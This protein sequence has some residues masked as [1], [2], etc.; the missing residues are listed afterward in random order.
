MHQIKTLGF[1]GVGIMGEPI[2]RHLAQKSKM[3]I[4]AADKQFAALERLSKFGVL[5]STIT[6]IA[7]ESDIIFMSL[8]S[9]EIVEDVVFGETGLLNTMRSD[10]IVVDLSTSRAQTAKK[11]GAALMTR[12]IYFADAPVMRTRAAA[13]S[14]TLGIPVGC[15]IDVFNRI[16]KFLKMFGSD[17]MHCGEIGSGQIA[18]I[19]NN[20][21]LYETVLALSEASAI[22]RSAGVDVAKIFNA[23]SEGSADSFALRNH[24]I[25]AILPQ[26]FPEKAFPVNY[27][28]KDIQYAVDLA[29]EFHINATGAKNLLNTFDEAIEQGYGELYAP[30]ISLL[31][32]KNRQS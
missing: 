29:S 9:G 12:G 6:E 21:V 32:E 18:K 14:G 2:C 5:T 31:F 11:V 23:M 3:K 13:E 7:N 26:N 27:A 20:M 17:I 22:A 28:R 25:K 4:L 10:K 8:P 30:A 24:G 1:I 19:L 15:N 16:E